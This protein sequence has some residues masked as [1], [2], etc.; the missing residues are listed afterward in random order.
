MDYIIRS[1]IIFSIKLSPN[2]IENSIWFVEKDV[3]RG[4]ILPTIRPHKWWGRN[5]FADTDLKK[6][7]KTGASFLYSAYRLYFYVITK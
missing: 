6:M 1:Q 5:R 3:K 4:Q 7:E 2:C